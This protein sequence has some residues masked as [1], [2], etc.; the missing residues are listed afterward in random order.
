MNR[1]RI[2]KF[3]LSDMQS[4]FLVKN[5][6][7]YVDNLKLSDNGDLLVSNIITRDFLSEFLKD[8]P[9]IRKFLMYFPEKVALSVMKKRAG[10]IRVNP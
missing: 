9:W 7:G 3:S 6:F 5:L 1:N 4:R 8:K 10:G 2:W